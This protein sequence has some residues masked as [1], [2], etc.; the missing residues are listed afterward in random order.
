MCYQGWQA[1]L[2]VKHKDRQH[3]FKTKKTKPILHKQ[4]ILKVSARTQLLIQNHRQ[5]KSNVCLVSNMCR[6]KH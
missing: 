6:G 2:P 1:Q 5:S 4:L 3:K